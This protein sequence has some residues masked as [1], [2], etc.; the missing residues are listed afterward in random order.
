MRRTA[1]VDRMREL[2]MGL[3]EQLAEAEYR[4]RGADLLL[5][6]RRAAAARRFDRVVVAGMGGSAIS[7]D[8]LR[9]LL[10]GTSGVPVQVCR[11][12]R[13]PAGVTGRSLLVAI[14]YSGNTEETLSAYRAARRTGCRFCAITSG[15]RLARSARRSG[16]PVIPVPPGL[17]PRAALGHLLASLL[18]CVERLGLTPGWGKALGETVSLLAGRRRGWLATARRTAGVL[19]DRLPLVYSTAR[20]LDPVADRWRCQLNENAKVLCHSSVLPEHNHNEIVGLGAPG[21]LRG[22]TVII[23][24]LDRS[25]HRRVEQRLRHTLRITRGA[26]ARYVGLRSEGRST[27][28]RMMSL[29]MLGDLTSVE[30]AARRGVDPMPVER[31]DELKRRMARG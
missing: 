27:L 10:A 14:S 3:P 16:V 28:A 9:S 19:E 18:V 30:L 1:S 13:L 4:A 6:R 24:L 5:P 25:T 2:V 26:Y 22:R 8:L 17:P 15:G 29:I 21:F 12:Y 23:G 31:I 7:G 20:L 11:D